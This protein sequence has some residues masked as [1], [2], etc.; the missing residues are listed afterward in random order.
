MAFLPCSAAAEE[1]DDEN[2]GANDDDEDR[3]CTKSVHFSV[4]NKISEDNT[5]QY[6]QD[7]SHQLNNKVN[8]IQF[9]QVNRKQ[10]VEDRSYYL[11][12]KI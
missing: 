11:S 7:Q 8:Y 4:V 10:Y 5:A 2:H 1:S 12:N 9:I 3:S 6:A